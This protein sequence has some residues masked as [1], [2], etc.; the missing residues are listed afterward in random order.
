MDSRKTFARIDLGAYSRNL[1]F[2]EE[3]CAPARVAPVIKADGYGH[4]ACQLARAVEAKA[5]PYFVVAFLEEAISLR[6]AGVR[7]PILVLNWFEPERVGELLHWDLTATL[8][9]ERQME[10]LEAQLFSGVLPVHVILDTGM[11][12]LGFR[13]QQLER[14]AARMRK[15][16]R[17]RWDG[18]YTHLA[19]ADEPDLERSRVQIREFS[20]V[21]SQFRGDVRWVHVSNSAGALH[22]P[23][24]L[25]DFV[26]V[27]IA[28][29]GLDPSNQKRP[30]GLSPV[31]HWQT[32]V[33]MVKEIP[34]GTGVSYGWTFVAPRSMK[35]ATVPVGYADG[36][37][38]LLS[39]T[40]QVLIQGKRAPILGRV[41]MDQFV[42]DVS[43]L[44]AVEMGEPVVLLGKMGS[45]EMS[46]EEMANRVQTIN[47]EI[48]CRISSRVPRI[49]TQTGEAV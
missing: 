39:N 7:S 17:F 10:A 9:C 4:G 43:H 37:N 23:E 11:S 6:E 16:R 49:F 26:R 22:L 24:G 27:G 31:L 33:A 28:S 14:V 30:A 38:R 19:T 46:C 42:V 34:R 32:A 20:E 8:F 48:T 5:F 40:G 41:C 18:L 3:H 13:P 21:A 29:Y 47:Y 36:Y 44:E 2:F 45:E 12:R 1:A 25:Y 35:V 15:T